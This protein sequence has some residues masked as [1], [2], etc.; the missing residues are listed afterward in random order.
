MPYVLVN[1]TVLMSGRFPGLNSNK[2]EFCSIIH[3]VPPVR[4]LPVIPG[5]QVYHL[6]MA[7]N[8]LN[9]A[10]TKLLYFPERIK[11]GGDKPMPMQVSMLIWALVVCG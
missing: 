6:S 7:H 1:N 11:K 8:Y 2:N 5:S 9:F 4:L 10:C 3:I